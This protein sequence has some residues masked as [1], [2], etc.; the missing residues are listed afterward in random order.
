VSESADL[1]NH[2]HVIAADRRVAADQGHI[3]DLGLRDQEPVEWVAM[4]RRQ[5]ARAQRMR[6]PDVQRSERKA[7][8]KAGIYR[9]GDTG[10]VRRPRSALIAI[11]Q[12]DAT[13]T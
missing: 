1:G 9:S 3:L 4:D 7:A 13:L 2:V 5:R 12:A 6:E 8:E 10:S 11:S